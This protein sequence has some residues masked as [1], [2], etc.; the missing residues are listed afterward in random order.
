MERPGTPDDGVGAAMAFLAK[1]EEAR[2]A[3]EKA[4][5][6]ANAQRTRAAFRLV[7]ARQA[8]RAAQL[9]GDR[10]AADEIQARAR[11]IARFIE[12]DYIHGKAQETEKAT[13]RLLRDAE[14][15]YR[16]AGLDELIH[17]ED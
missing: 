7:E 8:A 4:K 12:A 17:G 5:Y 10:C 9:K 15:A 13:A 3:A 11:I 6:T 14:F 2:A 16:T 1:V